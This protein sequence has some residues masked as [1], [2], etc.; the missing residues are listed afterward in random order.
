MLQHVRNNLKGVIAYIIVGIIIVPFALFGVEALVGNKVQKDAVAQVNGRPI[1]ELEVRR[2]MEFHKQQLRA[3]MGGKVDPKFLNDEFLRGAAIESLIQQ[4]LLE[5][6]VDKSRLRVGDPVIDKQIVTDKTFQKEGK[7]DPQYFTELLRQFAYTPASYRE[8][9][10]QNYLM[11]QYQSTFAQTAFVTEKEILAFA[12][13]QYQKRSFDYLTLPVSRT[14]GAVSVN[15]GE[16]AS[17]YDQ[18]KEQFL[19]DEEV[20]VE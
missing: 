8:E 17:Y 3:M 12:Q 5:S 9:L 19:S 16:I 7:F 14:V 13:L 1:T 11:S 4:R 20:A 6:G 18:H 10:R 15:D 2:S